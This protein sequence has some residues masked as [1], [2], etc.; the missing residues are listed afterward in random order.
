MQ[1]HY[2]S[3]CDL[4]NSFD[5]VA[6]TYQILNVFTL[7]IIFGWLKL[8]EANIFM[9][10]VKTISEGTFSKFK[11][12]SGQRATIEECEMWTVAIEMCS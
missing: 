7:Q 5:S 12:C 1:N 9:Y 4:R 10:G 3:S 6:F 2:N 8:P 11:N